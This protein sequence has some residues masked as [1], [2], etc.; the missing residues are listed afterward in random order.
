MKY[1][2]KM[3]LTL[4]GSQIQI[5]IDRDFFLYDG[6]WTKEQM[7]EWNIYPEHDRSIKVGFGERVIWDNI[8]IEVAK[9]M[10]RYFETLFGA[11]EDPDDYKYSVSAYKSIHKQITKAEGK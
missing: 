2:K 3:K 5:L 6:E 8:D 11:T 1:N 4:S 10:A 7:L 9:D